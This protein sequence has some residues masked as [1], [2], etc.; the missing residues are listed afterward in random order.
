MTPTIYLTTAG[1]VTAVR[2]GKARPETKAAVGPGPVFSIMRVPRP[3]YGEAGEG[4][5]LSLTPTMQLLQDV[6]DARQTAGGPEEEAAAWAR[7]ETGLLALWRPALLPPG[8]LTYCRPATRLEGNARRWDGNVWTP[9]GPVPEGATL[10]CSCGVEAARAGRCHRVVAARLL[11][12][13]GWRV[14]LDGVEV[15]R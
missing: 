12:E 13:Y 2:Q 5:V 14:V 6:R 11:A 10:I 7:Y 8:R 15:G 3:A 4:R 9:V 1:A